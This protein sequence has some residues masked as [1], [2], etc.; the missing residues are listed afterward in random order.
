MRGGVDVSYFC[1]NSAEKWHTKI[2][3]ISVISLDELLEQQ[4]LRDHVVII[5]PM[6][7]DACEEIFDLLI[8]KGISNDDIYKY[9]DYNFWK[10][11]EE[12]QYFDKIVTFGENE[13]FIDAGCFDFSTSE[14]F[15][16]KMAELKLEYKKIYAFEPDIVNV[17]R[18][19]EKI[20]NLAID[21]IELVP[22]GLG[23]VNEY[24][25]FFSLGNSSSHALKFQNLG[26][27]GVLLKQLDAIPE[28]VQV[29][30]L[31]TYIREKVTFI[32]MDI[33]G[34]ELEA[35]KGAKNILLKDKPKL[36]ICIYHKKE[37]LWEIP[38]YIKT[39]VPEYKLY[40]RH[41]S[42]YL[43]ETVLYAI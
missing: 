14:L 41:Y 36:A 42:N 33:E 17:K 19:K 9:L 5:S 24:Q 22:Y 8:E 15:I 27:S 40:I 21:K 6:L 10:E 39:L 30:S 20:D 16:K 29:I 3:D 43:S 34:A 18:C 4:L 1:D 31:D 11:L 23:S 26:E 35:L 38:Y 2:G 25:E 12:K 28:K 37:D 7:R 32:K 13:V